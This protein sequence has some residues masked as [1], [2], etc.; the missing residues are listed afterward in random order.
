[1]TGNRAQQSTTAIVPS[2]SLAYTKSDHSFCPAP[3]DIYSQAGAAP[4]QGLNYCDFLKNDRI[5]LILFNGF[6]TAVSCIVLDI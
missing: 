4:L 5:L 3:A 1:M 2:Y 6:H